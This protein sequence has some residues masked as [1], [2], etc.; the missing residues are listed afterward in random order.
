MM[1]PWLQFRQAT[2]IAFGLNLAEACFA[3][4]GF[5]VRREGSASFGALV[6]LA[7]ADR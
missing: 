3:G 7:H 5:S 4:A 1:S 6:R 2:G